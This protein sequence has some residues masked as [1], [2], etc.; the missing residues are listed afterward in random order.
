MG[1]LTHKG[2]IASFSRAF[3]NREAS[4]APAHTDELPNHGGQGGGRG[5]VLESSSGPPAASGEA[6]LLARE[7]PSTLLLKHLPI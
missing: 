7:E 4:A 5:V 2:A 3:L 6:G 1:F